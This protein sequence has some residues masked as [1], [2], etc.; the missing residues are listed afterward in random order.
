MLV[1]V[2]VVFVPVHLRVLRDALLAGLAGDQGPPHCACDYHGCNDEDGSRQHDPAAPC[3]MRDEQEDVDQEREEGDQQRRD[4]Q[5]QEREEVAGRVGRRLEVRGTCEPEADEDEQGRDRVHD[6]D[7]EETVA[8]G[9]R[10][11]EV[12]DC[13]RT[14]IISDLEARAR[15][16]FA[17]TQKAKVVALIA[18]QRDGVDD[19]RG[20]RAQQEQDKGD[21]EDDGQRRGRAK[22]GGGRGVAR[23]NERGGQRFGRDRGHQS[24]H[25][26]VLGR[27][28]AVQRQQHQR[29]GAREVRKY[30]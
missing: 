9:G 22:H 15:I 14:G 18:A 5:D 27:G 17:I 21:E 2:V 11:L 26:V 10:E 7:G 1:Q 12:R 8:G 24:G 3:H 4:G 23:S 29:V 30:C 13:S 16:A 19:R 25:G 6:E 20:Q 28:L